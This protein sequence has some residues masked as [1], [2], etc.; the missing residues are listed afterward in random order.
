M[1]YIVISWGSE[2]NTSV[3]KERKYKVCRLRCRKFLKTRKFSLVWMLAI[4]VNY[5]IYVHSIHDRMSVKLSLLS[6]INVSVIIISIF[7]YYYFFYNSRV[8]S[9]FLSTSHVCFFSLLKILALSP[10]LLSWNTGVL[11]QGNMSL[12]WKKHVSCTCHCIPFRSLSLPFF[13]ID[14]F[15]LFLKSLCSDISH[16][17]SHANTFSHSPPGHG[18]Q[19]SVFKDN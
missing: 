10:S 12:L 15:H 9:L 16:I 3:T 2:K 6:S 14:Q 8:R 13:L 7:L 5:M 4:I 11:I 1:K 19:H 18:N 17:S